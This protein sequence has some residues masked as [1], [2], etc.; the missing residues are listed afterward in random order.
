MY[1]LIVLIV[2]QLNQ[3]LGLNPK[4]KL[5]I[6]SLIT[7]LFFSGLTGC[8]TENRDAIEAEYEAAERAHIEELT[9][10]ER[11]RKLDLFGTESHQSELP[12]TESADE[13]ANETSDLDTVEPSEVDWVFGNFPDPVTGELTCSIISPTQIVLNGK[14]STNV[15]LVLTNNLVY[16]RTDAAID[17]SHPEA[18]VRIDAGLPLK[19]NQTVKEV[20]AVFDQSYGEVFTLIQDGSFLEV[21]YANSPH[22]GEEDLHTVGFDLELLTPL[23]EKFNDC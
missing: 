16:F 13:A 23:T 8:A 17:I 11:Q 21:R 4:H 9:S 10:S 7:L 2:I 3:G 15:N 14:L 19:F 6:C 12:T 22:K 5:N 1:F 20:S 18:G